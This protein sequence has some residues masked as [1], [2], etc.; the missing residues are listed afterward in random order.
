[1]FMSAEHNCLF[2]CT[3]PR[4][5]ARGTVSP[6]SAARLG[7]G[8]P[9]EPPARY[10]ATGEKPDQILDNIIRTTAIPL[11]TAAFSLSSRADE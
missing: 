7:R 4:R 6:I 9:K 3:V 2:S 8:F 11:R 5:T 10:L 1:M